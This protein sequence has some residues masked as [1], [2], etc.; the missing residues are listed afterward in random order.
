M[1]NNKELDM[2]KVGYYK[3]ALNMG[4]Q[5][6]MNKIA[7]GSTSADGKGNWWDDILKYIEKNPLKLLGGLGGMFLGS[8]LGKQL[9]GRPGAW[10]GAAA[11]TG[12]GYGLGHLF[13]WDGA[14]TTG[15]AGNDNKN[16]QNTDE[17]TQPP[18]AQKTPSPQTV[19]PTLTNNQKQQ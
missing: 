1:N 19:Q 4:R 15:P 8:L 18:A 10:A 3:M 11:G 13:K 14:N 16:Q 12:I 5:A 9:G 2:R 7:T 17:T 6:Y